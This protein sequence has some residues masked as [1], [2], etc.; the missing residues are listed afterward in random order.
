VQVYTNIE[1][2]FGIFAGYST[3]VDSVV[4][5]NNQSPL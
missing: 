3:D 2:G 5:E 1:N 4:L